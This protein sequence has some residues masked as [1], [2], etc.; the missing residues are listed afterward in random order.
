MFRAAPLPPF[1]PT[2]KTPILT[3]TTGAVDEE[4][5]LVVRRIA[6]SRDH[7]L[8]GW[9]LEC[10]DALVPFDVREHYR[11]GDN[12]VIV[13]YTIAGIGFSTIVRDRTGVNG[14]TFATA[15]QRREWTRYAAEG[16]LVAKG[17]F[18]APS[19]IPKTVRAIADGKTYESPDLA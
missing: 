9:L 4:R 14:Y 17:A 19:S 2:P 7:T 18:H 15:D 13:E 10:G 3:M 11:N 5:G 12:G 16:L 8:S 1:P 6:G